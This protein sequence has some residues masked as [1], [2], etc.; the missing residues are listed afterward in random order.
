[1]KQLILFEKERWKIHEYLTV[2]DGRPD[3]FGICNDI[4]VT[5]DRKHLHCYETTGGSGYGYSRG[6]LLR[7]ISF[8][9]FDNVKR[10][11][12]SMDAC[13]EYMIN[14]L[15][16]PADQYYEVYKQIYEYFS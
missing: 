10:V 15:K 2:I 9:D 3:E 13:K 14:E 16:I 11:P 1:M 4:V 7:E 12:Y 8:S 5:P 6:R